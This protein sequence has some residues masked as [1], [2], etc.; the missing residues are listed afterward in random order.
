MSI[1]TVNVQFDVNIITNM[2]FISNQFI[3]MFL[4]NIPKKNCYKTQGSNLDVVKDIYAMPFT[5]FLFFL[6]TFTKLITPQ[7]HNSYSR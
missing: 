6:L 3:V 5:W 2:N 1:S 4:L 7:C